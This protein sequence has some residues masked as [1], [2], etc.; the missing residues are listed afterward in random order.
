MAGNNELVVA[1]RDALMKSAIISETDLDGK[2]VFVNKE[3]ERALGYKAGEILGKTHKAINSGYHERD[4]FK[5]LWRTIARGKVWR[6]VV[7]N[8]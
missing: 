1:E 8:I 2:I 5:S 7:K 3:F 6:G 4:F